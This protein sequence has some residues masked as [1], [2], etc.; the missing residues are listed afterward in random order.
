MQRRQLI[1]AS[2]LAAGALTLPSVMKAAIAQTAPCPSKPIRNIVAFA[3]GGQTDS[4]ARL[5]A[6]QLT[7]EFG[8]QAIV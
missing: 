8:M 2:G 1:A 5:Y 3:A 7:A 6:K 4:Y